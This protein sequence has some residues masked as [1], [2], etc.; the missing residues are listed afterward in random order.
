MN[1]KWTLGGLVLF[2]AF[3][4]A[5]L[6]WQASVSAAYTDAYPAPDTSF[7]YSA[8]DLYAAAEAWGET[9]RSAYVHAR[10]TFDVIW[11]LVYGFF[12]TTSLAWLVGRAIRPGSRWRRVALLPMLVVLLDYAENVC[13]ATVMARY[14]TRTPILADL[15]PVFTASKWV[16]L[17]ACFA[18]LLVLGGAALRRRHGSGGV[19]P[20]SRGASPPDVGPAGTPRRSRPDGLR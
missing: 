2:G 18:L 11:P 17:S 10:V 14:P 5:V 3:I 16:L 9:G 7:W 12:L 6:P 1:L 15:A 13:A 4:A 20:G 8:R 19:M